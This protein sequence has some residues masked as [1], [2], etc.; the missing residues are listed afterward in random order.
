M[1]IRCTLREPKGIY[2]CTIEGIRYTFQGEPGNMICDVEN[3]RHMARFLGIDGFEPDDGESLPAGLFQQIRS[4]GDE[5]PPDNVR[6]INVN[7][8]S[9]EVKAAKEQLEREAKAMRKAAQRKENPAIDLRP[10]D[11]VDVAKLTQ[12]ELREYG[13]KLML[14]NPADRQQIKGYAERELGLKLDAR[15][16]PGTMLKACL[17]EMQRQQAEFDADEGLEEGLGEGLED[18]SGAAA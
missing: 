15:S 3:E 8:W 6:Q 11:E 10:V 18:E 16:Q 13:S 7:K 14:I 12:G 5:F 4:A 17:Q 2:D 1:R 9:A